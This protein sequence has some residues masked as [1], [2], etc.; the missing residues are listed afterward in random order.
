MFILI[1]GTPADGFQHFGPFDSGEL[2]NDH[3]DD[4]LKNLDWW[5]IELLPPV[6]PICPNCG[7][8]QNGGDCLNECKKRGFA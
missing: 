7:Q 1:C 2:A 3:G 4:S 6:R 8:W 5:V